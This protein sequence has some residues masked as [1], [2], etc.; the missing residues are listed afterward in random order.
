MKNDHLNKI[1]TDTLL[2]HMIDY[3]TMV[4]LSDD[5]YLGMFPIV[6]SPCGVKGYR[7]E[8]IDADKQDTTLTVK[9]GGDNKLMEFFTI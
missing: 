2:T 3:V 5:V 7:C 4:H 1:N 9:F 8:L 6:K